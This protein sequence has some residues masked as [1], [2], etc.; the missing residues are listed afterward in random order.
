[1]PG[2]PDCILKYM[3]TNAVFDIHIMLLIKIYT[4]DF[5]N[6]INRCSSGECYKEHE[7]NKMPF[8]GPA[9]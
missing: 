9:Q 2:K 3:R 8:N 6:D 4:F 5:L 1:M 7:H